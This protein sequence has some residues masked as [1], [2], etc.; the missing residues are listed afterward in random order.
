MSNVVVVILCSEQRSIN[1]IVPSEIG[2]QIALVFMG[3]VPETVA[4]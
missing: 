3:K 2:V 4:G 1:I